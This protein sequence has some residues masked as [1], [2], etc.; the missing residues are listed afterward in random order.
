MSC[1]PAV[2]A[3][4]KYPYFAAVNF[5]SYGSHLFS[6]QEGNCVLLYEFYRC[7]LV[8]FFL[9]QGQ[10]MQMMYEVVANELKSMNLENSHPQDYLNFYC[11]GNREE[12]PGSNNSGDQ[13]VTVLDGTYHPLIQ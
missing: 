5:L 10:T 11:L 2:K 6:S 4:C 7:E 9:L 12:V 13:T 1:F 3:F 8:F